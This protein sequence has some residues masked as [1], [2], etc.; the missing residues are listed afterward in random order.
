MGRVIEAPKSHQTPVDLKL[1]PMMLNL[2][3]PFE[4]FAT[5]TLS[6]TGGASKKKPITFDIEPSAAKIRTKCPLSDII[7]IDWL[8]VTSQVIEVSELIV[9]KN[10]P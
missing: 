10:S 4:G 5:V 9:A 8:K 6:I 2:L 3:N 7:A 1:V